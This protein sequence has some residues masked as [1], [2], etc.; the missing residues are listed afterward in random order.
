[1][2]LQKTAHVVLLSSPGIGH[3]IPII[4]LGKRFH[5]HHNFKVTILVI[6]SQSSQAESQILK[7]AT[8]PS[9]YTIIQIPSSNISSAAEVVSVGVI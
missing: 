1:M 5:I 4:E 8:N 9:L 6:T 3:L 7:S 2:D